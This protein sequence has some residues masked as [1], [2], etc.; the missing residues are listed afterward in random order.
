MKYFIPLM[1][2]AFSVLAGEKG[3][4]GYSIVCRDESKQITSAELL[5]IYEGRILY[6]RTYAVDQNSMEELIQRGKERVQNFGYFLTKLEKE[7]KL[8]EQNEV[9]IPIGNELEP[10]D[11]AFPVIRKTGCKFEQLANYTDSGELLISQ[12]IFDHL[13]NINRAALYLHE[14]IYSI[15]RKS[16]GD[17]TSKV[18]RKMV[19]HL[20]AN[21][22]DLTV[23]DSV[24]GDTFYRPNNKMVCG[25]QGTL[26]ERIESCSYVNIDRFGFPLVSRTKEGF[27]VWYDRQARILWSDRLTETMNF[28][29]AIGACEAIRDVQGLPDNLHWELPALE[30]YSQPQ[31]LINALPNMTRY[32]QSYWFWTK[33]TKGKWVRIFNGADGSIGLYLGKISGGSVRCVARL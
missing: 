14:A 24:V 9:F 3:N 31:I 10:T 6:K 25:V 11:D 5:D 18:T 12:E 19:A 26:E 30:D 22:A 29:K 7:L 13:D 33:T 27:E 17:V 32:G 1:L 4:G 28:E 15:R 16:V 21:N 20:M 2:I 8:I 23:I